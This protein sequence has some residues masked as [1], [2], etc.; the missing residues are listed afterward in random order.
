M[1][2]AAKHPYGDQLN[3]NQTYC[4]GVKCKYLRVAYLLLAIAS[5]VHVYNRKYDSRKRLNVS[6]YKIHCL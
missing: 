6:G 2:F 1:L 5:Y 4:Y 3:Y